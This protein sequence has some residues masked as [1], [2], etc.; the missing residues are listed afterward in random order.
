MPDL[1]INPN[2]LSPQKFRVNIHKFPN[3]QF[4]TQR[5]AIPGVTTNPPEIPTNTG[6]SYFH[7]ADKLIFE[8]FYVGFLMD[9]N[10][11][12]Y[13]E[14][15]NWFYE[16]VQT[17]KEPPFSDMSI[18]LLTNNS[19]S[20]KILKLYNAHPFTLGGVLLDVEMSEQTPITVD[21]FFKYSH[22]EIV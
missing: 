19:N 9:E 4:F 12:G 1:A 20:N 22:F 14:L 18:N 13:T 3:V 11:V 17:K 8:D 10:L 6:L 7:L 21:L 2:L 16:S 5:V 15:L